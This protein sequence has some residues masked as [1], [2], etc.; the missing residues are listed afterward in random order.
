MKYS[1]TGRT[2]RGDLQWL[3]QLLRGMGALIPSV[4]LRAVHSCLAYRHMALYSPP[5]A[6]RR[7]GQCGTSESCRKLL[8][9]EKFMPKSL[10]ELS[11]C[12][13][14][15]GCAI[16]QSDNNPEGH[17]TTN[18]WEWLRSSSTW[19]H[20]KSLQCFL[21]GRYEPYVVLATA[22]AP[23]Y[24]ERFEGYGKN[25]I[26][27]IQHLRHEDFRFAVMPRGFLLHFPHPRS[28]AKFRWLLNRKVHSHVDTEYARYLK[29]LRKTNASPFTPI[30]A[31][32]KRG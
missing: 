1:L 31:R 8:M 17:A 23:P 14:R 21:S 25:K 11:A 13:Q 3:C 19:S 28:T 4:S 30:C 29:E 15:K 12:F 6:F 16:F 32:N 24:D 20:L 18:S 7:R 5:T 9:D 26:Q 27:Y 2:Q 10:T 22:S